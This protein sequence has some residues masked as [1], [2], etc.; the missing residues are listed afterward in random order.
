[1]ATKK[2][3]SSMKNSG[4][5]NPAIITDGC[6]PELV[7]GAEFDGIFETLSPLCNGFLFSMMAPPCQ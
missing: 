2:K 5:K 4:V 7:K 1:M 6:N 3:T